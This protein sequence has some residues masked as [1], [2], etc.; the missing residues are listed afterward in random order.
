MSATLVLSDAFKMKQKPLVFVAP[1]VKETCTACG[2]VV[3]SCLCREPKHVKTLGEWKWPIQSL[4]MG[5]VTGQVKIQA[6]LG[7]QF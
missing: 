7:E 3:Q 5:P 1:Y 6:V 4:E 2:K